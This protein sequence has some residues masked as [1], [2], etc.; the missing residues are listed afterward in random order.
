MTPQHRAIVILWVAWALSWGI[1]SVWSQPTTKRPPAW[2]NFTQ[3]AFVLAGFVLLFVL[4][5]PWRPV[6]RPW[7]TLPAPLGWLA[8]GLVLAGLAF[9]WWARLHLGRLWSAD[10]ARKAG[11]HVVDSGPYRLVRHPIYSGLIL[12]AFAVAAD[13]GTPTAP[14]GAAVMTL[15]FY[16]KARMEERFLRAELGP[17][18][19]AYAARVPMLVPGFKF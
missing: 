4:G 13:F 7:W 5:R 1:A 17:A 18:Y 12:A 14:A 19:G 9:T 6:L 15:G 2:E 8:V 3:R 11:H 10:V 16:I